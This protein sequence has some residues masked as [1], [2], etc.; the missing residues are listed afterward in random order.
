[1][2]DEVALSRP[3]LMVQ[4]LHLKPGAAGIDM[5]IR[6]GEIVGLAGL[7]GHGQEE[8]LEIL[9]GLRQAER[10]VVGVVGR[11]G[12]SSTIRSFH[13][14]VQAGVAYLPRD[15]KTQGILP[16]LSVMDNFAVATLGQQGRWG[17]LNV[18]S[19]RERLAKYRERLA[20]V[21]ASP[22]APIT[23]LS[24]GNQQKV[25]L[26]RW[27]ASAP[28]VMLLNDPT[29]GVDVNTRS[30][31][32]KVFREMAQG[33]ERTTL[34][35]LSTEIEELLQLCDRTHV[36]RDGAIFATL[37]QSEM[38]LARVMAAMFGRHDGD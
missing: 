19:Q 36:F 35:L 8:F 12:K 20:M 25:L 34:V 7:E 22:A 21:F 18:R 33:Q 5:V 23:S 10:G 17:F 31:L 15:R 1:M 9:A 27:M 37:E 2:S 26:A 3:V 13:H 11:D 29:R 28:R 4:D 38:T 24:G 30:T 6:E 14:A 16:S 32:Y